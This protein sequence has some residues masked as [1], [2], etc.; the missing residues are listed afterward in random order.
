MYCKSIEIELPE[1]SD[2]L[3]NAS[4]PNPR[5]KFK[6]ARDQEFVVPGILVFKDEI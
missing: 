3:I 2:F 5:P 6:I 4:R 1:L